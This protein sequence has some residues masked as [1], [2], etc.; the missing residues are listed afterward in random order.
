[1]ADNTKYAAFDVSPPGKHVPS[2]VSH[3]MSHETRSVRR[4]ME[5]VADKVNRTVCNAVDQLDKIHCDVLDELVTS[6]DS[7]T[8]ESLAVIDTLTADY[9]GTADAVMRTSTEQL[10]AMLDEAKDNDEIVYAAGLA[11][12]DSIAGIREHTLCKMLQE[13]SQVTLRARSAARAA[14]DALKDVSETRHVE[15]SVPRIRPCPIPS[16]VVSVEPGA[17]KTAQTDLRDIGV[18]LNDQRRAQERATVAHARDRVRTSMMTAKLTH[19]GI[20]ATARRVSR[21]A[22]EIVTGVQTGFDRVER[23]TSVNAT[24]TPLTFD[25][26]VSI[27]R[28]IDRQSVLAMAELRSRYEMGCQDVVEAVVEG[29]GRVEQ[30]VT[31]AEQMVDTEARGL[32]RARLA[33]VQAL[34][35]DVAADVRAHP[36]LKVEAAARPSA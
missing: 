29:C 32:G 24:R 21:R 20:E 36:G 16:G 2:P 19:A 7:V 34:V 15:A 25:S 3:L 9:E 5:H 6:V 13:G 1:M 28:Q 22:A 8:R 18:R 26:L 4:E 35:D 31:E 27:T 33:S 30:Y 17:G 11:M 14:L 23:E 12:L 10:R